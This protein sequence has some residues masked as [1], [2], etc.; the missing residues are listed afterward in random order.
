MA[1]KAGARKATKAAKAS[2]PKARRARQAP[3][4]G[5]GDE[6]SDYRQKVR[7]ERREEGQKKSGC[8][9]KLF[10]LV[11]PFLVAATYLLLRS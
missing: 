1:R 8:V 2:S 11:L 7:E 10:V 6:V 3:R 5:G 9:P 4:R